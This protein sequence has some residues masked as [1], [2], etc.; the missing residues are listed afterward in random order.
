MPTTPRRRSRS[1]RGFTL[2]EVLVAILV[3]AVL[4]AIALPV[5]LGQRAR[6]QDS[7]AKSDLRNGVSQMESCFAEEQTYVGCDLSG[8]GMTAVTVSVTEPTTAY[9]LQETSASG[10]R[11]TLAHAQASGDTRTC[12][13]A[14]TE[15]GGCDGSVW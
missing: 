3:I 6:G 15:R 13:T 7:A 5:F 2:P 8:T 1:A 11:F 10:N 14:G 4:A 12:T 9:T